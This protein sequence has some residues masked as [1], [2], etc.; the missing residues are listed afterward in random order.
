MLLSAASHTALAQAG[1]ADAH[2]QVWQREL[3]FAKS[4]ADHDAAA[5]AEHLHP[6]AAFG[7]SQKPTRGREAITREWRPL[8]EGTALKLSWYPSVVTLGGDGR[9]AYSSGPALYEDPKT[10]DTRLGR[11][12]SVWHR[13]D[14]GVW[15]VLFDDGVTPQKADA[16]AVQ[17]FHDGRKAACPAPE[18]RLNPVG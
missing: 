6:E 12:G 15:Q 18:V 8:I 5:F 9:T 14:E 4:V 16:A 17:R 3:S 13:N 2:C 1:D 11:F 7:V 10:G